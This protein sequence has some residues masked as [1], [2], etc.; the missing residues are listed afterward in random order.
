MMLQDRGGFVP[1]DAQSAQQ[2]LK[3]VLT[4]DRQDAPAP[5][6]G[7]REGHQIVATV[8][9]PHDEAP[10]PLPRAVETMLAQH[11]ST[12]TAAKKAI[13]RR[14]IVVAGKICTTSRCVR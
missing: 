5:G 10:A 14:E 2:R 4:E 3:A 12:I 13:R 11:F 6:S 9:Y 7:I 8:I 1:K